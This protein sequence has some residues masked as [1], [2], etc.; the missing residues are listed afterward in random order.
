M[1]VILRYVQTV[2][3]TNCSPWLAYIVSRLYFKKTLLVCF[4]SLQPEKTLDT[5]DTAEN[6]RKTRHWNLRILPVLAKSNINGVPFHHKYNI[7]KASRFN[8]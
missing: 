4:Y 1:L 3:S 5:V 7:S 6:W 2:I 8:Q